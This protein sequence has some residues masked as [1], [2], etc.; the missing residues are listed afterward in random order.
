LDDSFNADQAGPGNWVSAIA[1]QSNGKVLLNSWMYA[2]SGVTQGGTTRLNLDGSFDSSFATNLP[3]SYAIAIQ[4]DA[5][6]FLV[7]DFWGQRQRIARYYENGQLDTS[8]DAGTTFNNTIK[9]IVVQT[10]GRIV[11]SGD[12]VTGTKR[13]LTNGL[14]DPSYTPVIPAGSVDCLAVQADN[15]VLI[16]GGFSSVGITARQYLARL[17]QDGSLDTNFLAGAAGPSSYV[18]CVAVQPDGKILVG[19]YFTS[20]NGTNRG[21][22]A[23]L[24]SDGSLDTSFGNGMT[25]AEDIVSSLVLQQDGKILISGRF[26]GVNGIQRLRFARLN[27]D[28]SV[29][30]TFLGNDFSA[31]AIYP[32]V[33]TSVIAPDGKIYVGGAFTRIGN[34][35][36]RYLARLHGDSP[37]LH[38]STTPNSQV[39]LFWPTGWDNFSAQTST[40]AGAAWTTVPQPPTSNGP[41]WTITLPQLPTGE[42]FRL[43]R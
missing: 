11:V 10:D 27:T 5:R 28:G 24:N 9:D 43:Q 29:D 34:L 33:I 37:L 12:F 20:M 35:G 14:T 6:F 23:R 39:Q 8:F 3:V 21:R 41:N 31:N 2:K 7:G 25:G 36:Q 30:T 38:I 17:N 40:N 32:D 42:I 13:L 16:G 26:G 18:E 15:K 1:V 4:P 19:G 22:V